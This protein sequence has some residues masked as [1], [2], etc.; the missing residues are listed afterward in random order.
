MPIPLTPDRDWPA[1]PCELFALLL[2]NAEP[3]LNC[4]TDR[5]MIFL[6]DDSVFSISMTL[7]SL[8]SLWLA[9][10][11]FSLFKN[12]LR[13]YCERLIPSVRSKMRN[14]CRGITGMLD[15]WETCDSGFFLWYMTI[16]SRKF[17]CL[18][19]MISFT[20]LAGVS[21]SWP[22]KTDR[23]K[24]LLSSFFVGVVS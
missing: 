2:N 17:F 4:L 24:L 6:A 14:S 18:L 20:S 3:L 10:Y 9:Y 12:Y 19:W 7:V 22:I 15:D 5:F 21:C 13:V 16:R 23:L 8:R 1:A 11:W